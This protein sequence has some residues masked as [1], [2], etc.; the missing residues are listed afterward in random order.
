MNWLA[1]MAVTGLFL[2]LGGILMALYRL[3][4]RL[5]ETR[6]ALAEM[7]AE[8]AEVGVVV[9]E[10]NAVTEYVLKESEDAFHQANV[11][12]KAQFLFR[13]MQEV[14]ERILLIERGATRT[15][16]KMT[17]LSR[18]LEKLSKSMREEASR[19]LRWE[20]AKEFRYELLA[21]LWILAGILLQVF[22]VVCGQG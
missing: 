11:E 3:L 22:A 17:G 16:Q 20:K 7:M 9:W 12:E 4:R 13:R 2:Q 1:V 6:K 18:R 19:T 15:Q 8:G 5:T 10:L 21:A 14:R